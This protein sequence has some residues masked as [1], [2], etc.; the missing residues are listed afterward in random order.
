[1]SETRPPRWA[2]VGGGIL[3]MTLALR[4]A[5]R[6]E[7]VTLY[8]AADHPGG[9]ADAWRLGDVRWDRHYHVILLS[10]ERTRGLLTELG[11]E[12][13]LKWVTTKTGFF[14]DG[15]LHSLS[16]SWEFL[17]FPP[18][19]L[20]DKL[21]L[22]GTILLASKI[23][24]PLPLE[25]IPVADWLR[26]WSGA[27]TFE[28]I[29]LPL[30][31]AKLGENYRQTSAAFIW[32]TIARM[33][34]A[35]RTGMKRELFGYLPGGYGRILDTFEAKLRAAGVE[36]RCDHIATRIQREDGQFALQFREKP[37]ATADRVVV[38]TPCN[39]VAN[40]CSQLAP[41]ERERL[42]GAEYQGIVCASLLL[43][44]P[45]SPYYVT[46]ITDAGL[47]FTAV[48]EMTSLVDAA[49]FGERSLVY[50]PKYVPTGDPLLTASDEAIREAFL[51][52]L[53]RMHPPLTDD[54]VLAFGVSRVPQVVALPTL[55]WSQRL[56]RVLTSIPG[57]FVVNSAQIVD[58]TLNV[59]ESVR[60][61]E[62][63]LPTLLPA[64]V[65]R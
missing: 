43:K 62:Q 30:L 37:G 26:K 64:E 47:P 51:A 18:L 2:I 21:R 23:R 44:R 65:A 36:L 53:R 25:K 5:E 32:S 10:D 50:L 42:L 38:T 39:I 13:E 22:A 33:Y 31:R 29:W 3:G 8:E 4:L 15:R 60:L 11:L 63:A 54:D 17:R 7:R 59:N 46:N 12:Q 16:S 41:D 6:G 45:L 48:I 9:L 20:L 28:K 40:L 35:R 58:G 34:K 14:T 52:G 1:M 56:P 55:N 19:R 61:A 57:L 27:R 49:E 24:D